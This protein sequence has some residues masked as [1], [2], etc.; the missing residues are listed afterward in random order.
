MTYI[1]RTI[2]ESITTASKYFP[3]IVIYG[4]R[5][6]G[7]STTINELFENKI[8]SIS[9]D[10]LEYRVRANENPKLFL[11]TIG[12]PIII[13][14]IQKAPLLLDEIKVI[15]DN[16]KKEWLKNDEPSKLLFILTGSNRFALQK[17]VSESLAGR[18]AVLEMNSLSNVERNGSLGHVFNPDV[19]ELLKRQDKSSL[20]Y[21]TRKE[22]FDEI[23]KGGMPEYVA[24]DM[25]RDIFFNSY[26]E[27]YIA[28]DVRNEIGVGM[29]VQ[30]R[31]F[32]NIIALR[33][34]AQVNNTD[35]SNKVGVDVRTIKKWISI[36]EASGL[37][38]LLHPYMSNMSDRIVK[39]PKLYFMDTGLCAYLCGWPDARM[40]E[41]GVMSGAFFETYV[42][43][44]II[45]N[46]EAHS[47]DPDKYLYYYRDCD[48]KEVDLL[49]VDLKGITPIEIKK[50]T[51][52]SKP[53]KNFNVLNKYKLP[54]LK[55]LVID[56]VEKIMPINE[57]A[58]S[59]PVYMLGD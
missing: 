7:K 12:Y 13:D 36:L 25:P 19:E 26:I 3:C 38:H 48:Q 46:L 17:K 11:E 57:M 58:Y 29:E 43:S 59:Y 31:N 24:K 55:G 35:I 20:K 53:T 49:Y 27:T 32:L 10:T 42:V 6:V 50:S 1:K 8:K 51:S 45:K 52:P 15:I 23:Y 14:E 41:N 54:I 30:F 9:L 33:T 37:I 16:K 47:I 21:K 22:I 44:D 5:Q 28:N 2:E 40:L 56:N 18:T 4:P 39:S 34:G